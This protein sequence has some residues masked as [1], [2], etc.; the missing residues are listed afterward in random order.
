MAFKDSNIKEITLSR[1]LT[2]IGTYAFYNCQNLVTVN[3][4]NVSGIVKLMNN[5][6][7]ACKNLDADTLHKI[8]TTGSSN[9]FY[10]TK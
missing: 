1:D 10:G 9:V 8:D 4:S 2:L 7:E 3:E 6:F 5:A